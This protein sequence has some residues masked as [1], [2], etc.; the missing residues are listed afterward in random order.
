M[1]QQIVSAVHYIHSRGVVHRDIKDEN[2]IIDRDSGQA[3]IIDFG[4]GTLLHDYYYKDFAGT[5]E[6]YPPEWFNQVKASFYQFVTHCVYAA[7]SRP[8]LALFL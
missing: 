3:K 2:I 4:C 7:I 1:M 6:F 8:R 5:P